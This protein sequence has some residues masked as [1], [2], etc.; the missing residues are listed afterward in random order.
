MSSFFQQFLSAWHESLD[1]PGFYQAAFSIGI[2]N[3]GLNQD[4]TLQVIEDE[5]DDISLRI[6]Q[7]GIQDSFSY[8]N[9]TSARLLACQLITD[10]GEIQTSLFPKV[11]DELQK[12]LY[13]LGPNRAVDS[14]MR[15]R[16]LRVIKILQ[17]NKECLKLLKSISKPERNR[18]AEA[19]IRETLEL[20]SL[21]SITDA[22]ARRAVLSALLCTLRQNV[23]SCFATAPA[24]LIHTELMV[25]FLTDVKDLLGKGALKRTFGGVE[26]SAPMS[27]SFGPGDLKRPI[28]IDHVRELGGAPG[29]LRALATVPFFPEGSVELDRI[30][31]LQMR[32][33]RL[34]FQTFWTTPEEILKSLLLQEMKLSRKDLEDYEKRLKGVIQSHFLV[35]SAGGSFGGKSGLCQ[36]FLSDFDLAKN[37]FRRMTVNPL[38]KAWEYTL[39]S[40]SETKIQFTRWN[41]YASL[42]FGAEDVGGIGACLYKGVER[43]LS[44]LNQRVQELQ[45]EY[46]Q[47]YTQVKILEGRVNR[48]A[49]EQEWKWAKAEYESRI[50]EFYTFEEIRNETSQRAKKMANLFKNLIEAFD[51]LFPNYFQEVYDADLQ[52]VVQEFYDD[53]PA[54]FRL[55]FKHGRSLTAQWTPIRNPGEW[56]QALTSF[57]NSAERDLANQPLFQGL[58]KDVSE[59]FSELILHV[60]TKEFLETAFR[61]MA[62]QHQMPL[63]ANPLDHLEKI[64]KKPWA[65]TSGGVMSS[66]VSCYFRLETSPKQT[67]RWVESPTEL[68]IFLIDTLKKMPE[69]DLSYFQESEIPSL[70][71]NSPTHAFLLKPGLS[72]FKKAWQSQDFTYTWLRDAV[73]AP[74][75]RFWSQIFLDSNDLRKLVLLLAPT[76]PKRYQNDFL[77]A[78]SGISGKMTPS[79]FRQYLIFY[80][81]K[82][83]RLQANGKVVFSQDEIDSSLYQLLPLFPRDRL[84]EKLEML[85]EGINTID[86]SVKSSLKVISEDIYSKIT[87]DILSAMDLRKVAKGLLCLTLEKSFLSFNLQK[88]VENKGK[89]LG[90]F[91]PMPL[92][93]AD[94]NWP[95]EW[96]GFVVNPGSEKFELWR[97]DET[98]S[99]GYPMSG[100]EIWLNGSRKDREWSIYNNYQEYHR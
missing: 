40:F 99:T 57:F 90:F 33:D 61:R 66:F 77:S 15:E 78:F 69:K 54:G 12:N 27:P 98:G 89:E 46:E 62:I 65:Y 96:F 51:S 3:R 56:I 86:E 17:E 21:G 4:P 16:M 74:M 100:W 14:A 42:G 63:I 72:F 94:T 1:H 95:K 30:P 28:S 7:T 5:H 48:A 81:E 59:L 45:I 70:L 37:V 88:E 8:R 6:D 24:I 44:V 82:D 71:M 19:L 10:K 41:L 85:F 11:I 73:I 50:Q 25:Q 80:M 53:S 79:D 31:F 18:T 39:A 84:R 87:S 9:V 34:S 60:Q 43:R 83:K 52:D 36:K 67:G 38:L 76:L 49:S 22:H 97:L 26:L 20:S 64:E 75:Q 91:S 23:G 2:K 55:H 32:L 35:Q 13:S 47:V 29:L 58:E 92:L 93:F 68:A